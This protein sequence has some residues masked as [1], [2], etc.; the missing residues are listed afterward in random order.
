[1]MVLGSLAVPLA[2][3]RRFRLMACW[4]QMGLLRADVGILL[5]VRWLVVL[6]VK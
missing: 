2:S 1:M 6:F 3:W 5:A 4:V